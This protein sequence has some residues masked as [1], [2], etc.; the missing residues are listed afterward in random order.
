MSIEVQDFEAE[1]IRQSSRIPVVVDF[2]AAWC[3]PCRTLSPVLERLEQSDGGRW[4]LAKVDVDQHQEVAMQFGISGI[5][6]VKM[7]LGGKPAG[8]FVGAVP[9]HSVRQWLD[10]YLPKKEHHELERAK[11][12]L[13]AGRTA[14]AQGML[15]SIVRKEPGNSEARVLLARAV[16]FEDPSGASAMVQDLTDPA[17]SEL[18][19]A[20]GTLA[21]LLNLH[22]HPE[23][24]P[25]GP[26][27]DELIR[28]I[29]EIA[30]RRFDPALERL[31]G[32]IR[33]DRYY[34]DD[35]ARKACIAIFKY[36]GEDDP[37][38]LKYRRTFSSALY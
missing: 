1:V 20:I 36:L 4:L 5:P 28:T 16:L 19:G 29:G 8:E 22:R 23:Q 37:V 25:A 12:L 6:A 13:A 9:E 38:T 14:E 27:R 18:A 26:A 33:T 10:K 17:V 15:D 24:L 30:V 21:E 32:I 11:Q 3:G 7:F 2:W 34:N 31:I 35:I